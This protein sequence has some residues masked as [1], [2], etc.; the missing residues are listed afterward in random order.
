MTAFS[1]IS[2]L[3]LQFSSADA[4]FLSKNQNGGYE[5][6]HDRDR[7]WESLWELLRSASNLQTLHLTIFHRQFRLCEKT[8]LQPLESLQVPKFTVQ[9]PWARD[10]QP[11][12]TLESDEG[13]SF[14]V[15]R[16]LPEQVQV[17]NN[18]RPLSGAYCGRTLCSLPGRMLNPMRVICYGFLRG[19][20][21]LSKIA[22]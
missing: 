10:Y 15:L 18:P 16:P 13:H 20:Q 3:K 9:L 8:Y 21:K 22:R 7:A 19:L 14:K 11:E 1:S 5:P 12:F 4:L 6:D 2:T 17:S